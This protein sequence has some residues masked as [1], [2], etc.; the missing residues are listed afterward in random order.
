MTARD[1]LFTAAGFLL[2]TLVWEGLS[3]A[4]NLKELRELRTDRRRK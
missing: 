4:M 1:W 2:A 3:I